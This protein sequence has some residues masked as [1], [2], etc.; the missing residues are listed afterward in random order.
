MNHLA[1]E[2]EKSASK[3]GQDIPR[4]EI[5]ASDLGE[6]IPTSGKHADVY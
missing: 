3:L 5:S 6:E 4:S 2:V 1:P